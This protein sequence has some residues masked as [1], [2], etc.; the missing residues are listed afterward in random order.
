MATLS[1]AEVNSLF[2]EHQAKFPQLVEKIG[3]LKTY[4]NEKM[5][6]QMT[7]CMVVYV[8]E[9]CFDS[10]GDGN[11]LIVFYEKLVQKLNFRLNP[12]KYAMITILCSR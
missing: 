6:H 10:S 1:P 2:D 5:W 8:K 3:E 4:Y 12:I 9:S 11:E 7:D